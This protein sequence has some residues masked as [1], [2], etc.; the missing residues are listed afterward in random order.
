MVQGVLMSGVMP[1]S[2]GHACFRNESVDSEEFSI[3][4]V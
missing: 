4:R 3:R 2:L 1:T